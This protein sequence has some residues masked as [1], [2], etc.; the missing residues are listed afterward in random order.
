MYIFHGAIEPIPIGYRCR[1]SQHSSDHV[2][3]DAVLGL[4]SCPTEAIVRERGDPSEKGE[5]LNDTVERMVEG[6]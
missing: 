6:S 1:I 5:A 2:L 4:T 3:L